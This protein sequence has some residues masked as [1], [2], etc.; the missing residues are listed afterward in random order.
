MDL[1]GLDARLRQLNQNEQEL[2][3]LSKRDVKLHFS[4]EPATGVWQIN[5][6]MLLSH[7]EEIAIHKH[8]RFIEFERHS[9]DYLEM[10][11]VYDGTITHHFE[12]ETLV[13]KKGE[14]LLMDMNVSH[15][16]EA[17]FE[18]DIAVNLLMKRE[19]FDTFFLRQIAYNNVIS[20]FVVNAIYN[21]EDTSKYLYFKTG[22][23]ERLYDLVCQ[24]LLEYYN[25]KNGMD[26]AIR[27]YMLLLFNELFRNY[28]DYLGM[29]EV[30]RIDSVIVLEVM[31][32]IDTHYKT[33]SLK[34]MAQFFNYNSDY[35]G[36]QIKK[37]TG[38]TLRDIVK[39]KKLE[40]AARLLV[41]TDL[42]IL[43]I[44]ESIGYANISYFY[45][46]FKAEYGLTPDEYRKN[47]ST[48]SP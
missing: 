3:H 8:D 22:D 35:L 13:Q 14:L 39:K 15:S 26:T 30:A 20:N 4:K 42:A 23:Q 19:F 7:D 44:L 27:A 45:K 37:M 1:A 48:V 9:H 46:Q 29:Q 5:Q 12:N 18:G 11:F 34:E 17:A 41:N 2:L 16:I 33:V 24:I 32:Y 47:K 21:T 36:K 40:E 10:M 28:Q 6:E 25:Q 31:N 43:R 38:Y